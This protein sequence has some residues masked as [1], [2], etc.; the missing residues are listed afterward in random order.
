MTS[1]TADR[2]ATLQTLEDPALVRR[3]RDGSLAAFDVLVE[4]HYAGV[5]GFLVDRTDDDEQAADL[6][7]EAFLDAFQHL[8]R[9]DDQRPFRAW[10]YGIAHHRL[11]RDWRRQPAGRF[12]SLEWLTASR[13][14]ATSV[15]WQQDNHD[16]CEEQELLNRALADLTPP[17]REVLLLNC[18][19]G[20]T[21]VEIGQILG[22]SRSAAERRLSRA[23]KQFREAYVQENGVPPC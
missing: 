11:Q 17:M 22:I 21:A 13:P 6:A 19:E 4:R 23:K 5:V 14:A 2:L 16:G 3:A 15:F 12:V 18:Q 7:Q 8:T 10:L 20:F 9:C 1:V